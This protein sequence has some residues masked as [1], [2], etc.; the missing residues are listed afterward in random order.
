M[1]GYQMTNALQKVREALGD[2]YEQVYGTLM[3][4]YF[5]PCTPCLGLQ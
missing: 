3:P 1:D 2:D 4:S 5:S